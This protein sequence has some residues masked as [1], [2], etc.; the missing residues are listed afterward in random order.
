[1]TGGIVGC[2]LVRRL[3]TSRCRRSRALDEGRVN[4]RLRSTR[5]PRQWEHHRLRSGSN[6][7]LLPCGLGSRLRIGFSHIDGQPTLHIGVAVGLGAVAL[8]LG[9][10]GLNLCLK[11]SL[12]RCPLGG[13]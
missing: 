8:T 12:G 2:A 1:V 3:G 5:G 7:R 13:F 9:V 10:V 4:G 11:G 6:V